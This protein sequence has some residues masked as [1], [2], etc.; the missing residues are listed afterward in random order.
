V[1][2]YQL[3]YI[4]MRSIPAVRNQDNDVAVA[5]VE[6]RWNITERW[7]LVGFA[8]AGRAWGSPLSFSDAGNKV[9]KG[10]GFRYQIARA[11]GMWAGVDFAWGPDG[12]RAVYISVGNSWRRI[13]GDR[14]WS[15][16]CL[17]GQGVGIDG[18]GGGGR[19]DFL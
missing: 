1:P 15:T 17:V 2:F 8:R 14:S 7:R 18:H 12:E 3:P 16:A 13:A 9:S 19:T 4:D 6:A 11:F 5:E 10:A